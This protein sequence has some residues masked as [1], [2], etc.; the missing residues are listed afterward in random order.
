MGKHIEYI[1]T[2]EA[3]ALC[4]KEGYPVPGGRKTLSK[5]HKQHNLGDKPVGRLRYDKEK[6]LSLIKGNQNEKVKTKSK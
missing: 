5:W 2:A 4:E 1:S 6:L 3:L